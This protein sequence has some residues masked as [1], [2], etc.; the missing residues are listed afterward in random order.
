MIPKLRLNNLSLVIVDNRNP[1]D[2]YKTLAKCTQRLN[3]DDIIRIDNAPIKSKEDYSRYVIKDLPNHPKISNCSSTHFLIV[4]TDGY[5]INPYCWQDDFMKYDYIG[6]P[7]WYLTNNVGNGGF[8]IRSKR[9][10]MELLNPYYSETH[11]EDDRIG[12]K[13]RHKLEQKGFTFAPE[14]LANQFSFEPNPKYPTFRNN[15][16]GFHG[17]KELTISV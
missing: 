11:P 9:L 6:A 4:Q 16:F 13:Y 3:F 2:I 14:W 15:T 1:D 5:V 8:S 17:I 7:W 10:M 12:R